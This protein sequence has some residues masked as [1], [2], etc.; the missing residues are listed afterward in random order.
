MNSN[1]Q[2]ALIVSG[3]SQKQK[4]CAI[5]SDPP[6]PRGCRVNVWGYRATNSNRRGWPASEKRPVSERCGRFELAAR[7]YL[8]ISRECEGS[9]QK[10]ALPAPPVNPLEPGSRMI[11]RGLSHVGFPV[12]LRIGHALIDALENLFFRESG[13]FQ[14]PDFRA[15]HGALTL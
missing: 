11:A 14:A 4:Q 8:R 13:I 10:A 12:R 1:A 6:P 5:F 15:A 3:K 2:N 7:R 9:N